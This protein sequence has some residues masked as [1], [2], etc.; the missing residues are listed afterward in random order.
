MLNVFEPCTLQLG[1]RNTYSVRPDD[2][3]LSLSEWQKLEKDSI[4][5]DKLAALSRIWRKKKKNKGNFIRVINSNFFLFHALHLDTD[6]DTGPVF[7]SY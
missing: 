7:I 3:I 1:D 2:L 4:G 5:P 6:G